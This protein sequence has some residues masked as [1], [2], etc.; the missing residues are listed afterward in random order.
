MR[1]PSTLEARD[2]ERGQAL[3]LLAA[4]FI[5]L[6]AFVGLTIDAG[7]LFSNVGHLRRATDAAS[8]AAANQFREG[9]TP[10]ELSSMAYEYLELNGL[11]PSGATAKICHLGSPGSVYDDPSLCPGGTNPPSGADA[12]TPRKYIRVEATLRVDFAFLPIIGFGSTTIRAESIS[13]A[14]SVDLVLAIYVSDSMSIDLCYDGEDNDGDAPIPIINECS[15]TTGGGTEGG[16]GTFDDDV[17][18]CVAE[19][20]ATAPSAR[21]SNPNTCHPFEEVRDAAHRLVDR[22]YFPYDRISIVTFGRLPTVR[23]ELDDTENLPA[24]CNPYTGPTKERDCAHAVLEEIQVE[25]SPLGNPALC[26]GATPRGCMSTNIGGGLLYS[27]GRFCLDDGPPVSDAGNGTCE[28]GEMREEAVWIVI[29]LTDGAANAATETDPPTSWDHWICPT[30]TYSGPGEPAA[31][32]CRDD[33]ASTRHVSSSPNYDADDYARDQADFVGCPGDNYPLPGCATVDPKGGNGAVIFTIGLGSFVTDN[34]DDPS[35]PR[36]GEWFL[37]YAAA[38][39]DDGDP[40]TDPCNP[41]PGKGKSCGNYYFSP[42]GAG[43]IK[44]FEDIASRIFTR[45]SH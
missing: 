5:G 44:V 6:A 18:L 28:R 34:P 42:D 39:G 37:R 9:R 17:A 45:I 15:E 41:D 32:F 19:T 2:L 35:E 33:D 30:N 7:I 8:L 24:A 22:L 27:G 10:L 11:S 16:N 29:L 14:A 21:L 3:A 38:A 25:L 36:A 13:E 1:L 40:A 20:L 12:D 4:A 43:L 23:L 26:E 31:P